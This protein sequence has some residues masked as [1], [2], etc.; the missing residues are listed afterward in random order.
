[1]R[2]RSRFCL[3]SAC[4]SSNSRSANSKRRA[5]RRTHRPRLL[6]QR[7]HVRR[8]S[9]PMSRLKPSLTKNEVE[10]EPASWLAEALHDPKVADQVVH[11]RTAEPRAALY[12]KT[13]TPLN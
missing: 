2:Y 9:K 3:L 8:L 13:S 11:V 5:T 4:T 6:R 7:H 12:R 10:F 1:W